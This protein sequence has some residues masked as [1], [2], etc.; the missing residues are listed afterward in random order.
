MSFV[1]NDEMVQTFPTER[2]LNSFAI[3]ILPRTTIGG[4]DALD[5]ERFQ[6]VAELF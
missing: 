2:S 4:L 5:T 6:C 1:E 3:G